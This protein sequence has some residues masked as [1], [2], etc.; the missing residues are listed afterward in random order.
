MLEHD[1]GP[2]FTPDAY[3]RNMARIAQARAED[4]YLTYGDSIAKPGDA[5]DSS[6]E[7]LAGGPGDPY[8]GPGGVPIGGGMPNIV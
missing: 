2:I 4:R 1:R 6:G 5:G 8:G 7:P 3:A